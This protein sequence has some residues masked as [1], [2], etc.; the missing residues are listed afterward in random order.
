MFM[1][2]NYAGSNDSKVYRGIIVDSGASL[3]FAMKDASSVTMDDIIK[4]NSA[5]NMTISADSTESKFYMNNLIQN[6]NISLSGARLVLASYDYTKYLT[7]RDNYN[8]YADY[9]SKSPLVT[10]TAE[11]I[12][13]RT[14]NILKDS[15]LDVRK[16]EIISQ[17]NVITNYVIGTLTSNASVKYSIDLDVINRVSDTFSVG[18]GSSGTI[19]IVDIGDISSVV[20]KIDGSINIKIL[21][22]ADET[23]D[24]FGNYSINLALSKELIDVNK[25]VYNIEYYGDNVVDGVINPSKKA[26]KYSVYNDS[27]LGITGVSIN[28]KKD[29]IIIGVVEK[30]KTLYEINKYITSVDR[31][32]K[33]RNESVV[34]KED[35]DYNETSAGTFSII[36]YSSASSII[37]LQVGSTADKHE[38]FNLTKATTF[39]V[40]D[41]TIRN[42]K[43]ALA[44]SNDKA[45]ATLSYV[46]LQEN[47]I[48]IIKNGGTIIL[49]AVLVAIPTTGN[50]NYVKNT[51]GA[52]TLMN[53]TVATY[54]EN[55][56]TLVTTDKAGASKNSNMITK[57]ENSGITEVR[58][59]SD[60]IT[61]IENTNLVNVYGK[62]KIDYIYNN[63]KDS[64]LG[65]GSAEF[66][67]YAGSKSIIDT[68]YNGATMSL[69]GAQT[70]KTVQN[71][72]TF[73]TSG[74]TSI[75]TFTNNDGEANFGGTTN[76]SND[77]Q[78]SDYILALLN[79]AVVNVSSSAFYVKG[80]TNNNEVYFQTGSSNNIVETFQNNANGKF[81]IKANTTITKLLNSGTVN[82]SMGTV[83]IETLTNSAGT[84]STIG[85]ANT[86]IT[87]ADNKFG[88]TMNLEGID[89]VSSL[90]N[91][92]TVSVDNQTNIDTLENTGKINTNGTL[93]LGRNG[94]TTLDL[95]TNNGIINTSGTTILYGNITT[96]EN[97]SSTNKL[98]LD[99]SV[100]VYGAIQNDQNVTLSA[101]GTLIV[102]DSGVMNFNNGDVWLGTLNLN[103]TGAVLNY[104]DMISNDV[105][106]A[107]FGT[108][109][110]NK[111]ALT[112]ITTK[113]NVGANSVIEN[114]V[115]LNI[116]KGAELSVNGGTL[117]I[118]DNDNWLGLIT[119]MTGTDSSGDVV[120]GILNYTGSASVG[121]LKADAGTLNVLSNTLSL[122]SGSVVESDVIV[123][124]EDGSTV[125]LNGGKLVL[126]NN[127]KWNGIVSGTSGTLVFKGDLNGFF[128][129]NYEKLKLDNTYN[130]SDFITNGYTS[131]MN[132]EASKTMIGLSDGVVG[133]LVLGNLKAS[134]DVRM[135]IDVDMQNGIADAIYA[136][137]DS[138]GTITITNFTT[139][140][141]TSDPVIIRVLYTNSNN[142]TLDIADNLKVSD[143]KD[144]LPTID[145]TYLVQSAGIELKKSNESLSYYDSLAVY[146]VVTYDVLRLLN[147][148]STT[149]ERHFLFNPDKNGNSYNVFE[150]LGVTTAGKL[151]I[152]GSELTSQ[153][154]TNTKSF[155]DLAGVN[156][157][158]AG[159]SKISH[160]GFELANE[161]VL[162]IY[163]VEFTDS[164]N[165]DTDLIKVSNSN[166]VINLYN[167]II[168]G[169]ISGIDGATAN[170]IVSNNF[171]NVNNKVSN[172]H[173]IIDGKLKNSVLTLEG[174]KLTF[175]ENTFANS[176]FIANGGEVNL[177]DGTFKEY[178]IKQMVSSKDVASHIKYTEKVV[179]DRVIMEMQPL[180][181]EDIAKLVKYNLD[182]DFT[183]DHQ[184]SDTF[185]ILTNSEGIIY[186]DGFNLDLTGLN[187]ADNKWYTLQIIKAADGVTK[188]PE[189]AYN[190]SKI[191]IRALREMRS[192]ML[193]VQDFGLSTTKTKNDSISLHGLLNSFVQWA[194][195][196]PTADDGVNP[197]KYTFV[198][199][200]DFIVNDT[201]PR[202]EG[203]NLNMI[204]NYATSG[205]DLSGYSP[206]NI[207]NNMNLTIQQLTIKDT[208]GGD[209]PNIFN[210][211]SDNV[212]LNLQNVTIQG[213]INSSKVYN[214]NIS[215]LRD[216][217]NNVVTG[218]TNILGT[219]DKAIV[220][221]KSGEFVFSENT[222]ANANE[223]KFENGAVNLSNDGIHTY[224]IN[225]L[226]S[227][228]SVNWSMDIDISN[229][230]N[231]MYD[232]FDV[233]SSSGAGVI[234]IDVIEGLEIPTEFSD[235][236]TLSNLLLRN[237]G[238]NIVLKLSD[239]LINHYNNIYTLQ[240]NAT[241]KEKGEYFVYHDTFI[242]TTGLRVDN[243]TDLTIGILTQYKPLHEMNMLSLDGK[244]R[245]YEFRLATTVREEVNLSVDDTGVDVGTGAGVFNVRGASSR[246]ED[247]IID[248]SSINETGDI[249]TRYN[250]FNLKNNTDLY[251]Q[252][253][254]I[255]QGKKALVLN[256][257]NAV[258]S[259]LNVIF[260]DNEVAIENKN[261][262]VNLNTVK[263]DAENGT[264]L[265]KVINESLMT[266]VS[267]TINSLTDNSGTLSISGTSIFANIDNKQAGVVN[268]ADKVTITHIDNAGEV[269]AYGILIVT[270]FNNNNG[271]L[272][273]NGNTT[274]QTLNNEGTAT[275]N[276]LSDIITTLVNTQNVVSLSRG[277]DIGTL[278]NNATG[279]VQ[280]SGTNDQ[281][282]LLD[283]YGNVSTTNVT[284]ITTLNNYNNI[285][286]GG[287]SNS[288]VPA[289]TVDSLKNITGATLSSNSSN[290]L[291]ISK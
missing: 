196:V 260:T 11:N 63:Y 15:T 169:N 213:N 212:A 33:F 92:G 69:A 195:Y 183:I 61:T 209:A 174:G 280:L 21:N 248:L 72:G 245:T 282:S 29:S 89:V 243:D 182:I 18:A 142:L 99:G 3:V 32:Y 255:V 121:V 146:S 79:N 151:F 274:I 6:A 230:N 30:L 34:V 23:T 214:L 2:G 264:Q 287:T 150:N 215:E 258:S 129:V 105:I 55:A 43:Y 176:S 42:G 86:T 284:A 38:G 112:G 241:T 87:S 109:N 131:Q 180:S 164:V 120:K 139:V 194:G 137:A 261:G 94:Q 125:D 56:G 187:P 68:V 154:G 95:I 49:D 117:N 161:T 240:N 172:P 238:D 153:D 201:I 97:G 123:N 12:N 47:D 27:F 263:V 25:R 57:I 118:N 70:I 124:I 134:N 13:A 227:N 65:S 171:N 74:S 168:R 205:L 247:S 96:G 221:L 170:I 147:L 115:I 66:N 77:I 106:N 279:D 83:G 98:N 190:D 262:D 152:Q 256:N 39:N 35:V 250:G 175:N 252:N 48:A 184:Y 167:S 127:D 135:T 276:G 4:G 78:Y 136:G 206:L 185:K 232:K 119:M 100:T 62:A 210:I 207:E 236:V 50:G 155:L 173:T 31:E 1:S 286:L 285:V 114:D 223:V 204:G 84:F 289:D 217:D 242:G 216:D 268:T 266:I 218:I 193:F 133:N 75:D 58:G 111:S 54:I 192:D 228:E 233:R 246:A 199:N 102:T 20:S 44:M 254:S 219:L 73:S 40:S 186:I 88:A 45:S 64:V 9:Q 283:N 81:D 203:T 269:N 122:I 275:L 235:T 101:N 191:L 149:E 278:T 82:I 188:A 224:L 103:S 140:S 16:G 36:G 60:T 144:I 197:K 46:T 181:S 71:Y 178:T 37:D 281:V 290:A 162:G 116:A 128:N 26:T 145:N 93:T 5:F 231:L 273:T 14:S 163:N 108:I 189:L 143:V 288:E 208:K 113:L 28:D 267:S 166:A 90:I 91:A 291:F 177:V 130:P 158:I 80:F 244:T 67:T 8:N 160:T 272:S 249:T 19:Q 85:S 157:N 22:R 234:T 226:T 237:D 253:I 211:T 53:T 271:T 24:E 51:K 265:N 202:L 156:P 251:L 138:S 239:N 225:N 198:Y 220:W 270:E 76:I 52:M 257:D 107:T 41:V 126:D 159:S 132:V 10:P 17:D 104:V 165:S 110:I 7:N 148:L 59:S 277:L 141:L 229:I 200:N 222:L 259:L 179:G